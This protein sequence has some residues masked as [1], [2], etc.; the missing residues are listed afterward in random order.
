MTKHGAAIALLIKEAD[1]LREASRLN[2][3]HAKRLEN[4]ETYHNRRDLK[5]LIQNALWHA[6]DYA[7][8]AD[9][10]QEAI[11]VLS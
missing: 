7:K 3:E 1:S 8:R 5:H 9:K 2:R 11:E 4:E 10:L 6:A